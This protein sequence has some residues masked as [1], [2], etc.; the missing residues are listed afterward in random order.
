[1]KSIAGKKVP[2]FGKQKWMDTY[3]QD[4]LLYTG[5][6]QANTILRK[7]GNDIGGVVALVVNDGAY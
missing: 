1:M 2:M 6:V 7:P 4:K 3:S 5:I